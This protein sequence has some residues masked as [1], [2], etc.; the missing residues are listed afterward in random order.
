MY[1]DAWPHEHQNRFMYFVENGYVEV[2]NDELDVLLQGAPFS[3]H[4]S[5]SI[6][7]M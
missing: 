6:C 3:V 7:V 4:S 2:N 1:Y 5:I